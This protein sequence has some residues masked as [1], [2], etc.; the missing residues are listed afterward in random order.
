MWSLSFDKHKLEHPAKVLTYE[1]KTQEKLASYVSNIDILIFSNRTLRVQMYFACSIDSSQTRCYAESVRCQEE[2]A[3]ANIKSMRH[4]HF[5]APYITIDLEGSDVKPFLD[6]LQ[7]FFG[8]ATQCAIMLKDI[9]DVF[10]VLP[11]S[12]QH[13]AALM[14][15]VDLLEKRLLTLEAKIL[16]ADATLLH[17]NR[18][19]EK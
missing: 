4:D 7:N 15:K 3:K 9:T 17:A 1:Y 5:F 8:E 18:L 10:N 14:E 19:A 11:L 16:P 13:L 6:A 2:F 12:F